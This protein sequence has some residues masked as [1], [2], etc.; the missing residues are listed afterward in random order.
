MRFQYGPSR[1]SYVNPSAHPGRG[2]SY[3]DPGLERNRRCNGCGKFADAD[4][5]GNS[6]RY[7][8]PYGHSDSYGYATTDLHPVTHLYSAANR[9]TGH[10]DHRIRR[11][12]SRG[13]YTDTESGVGFLCGQ[14]I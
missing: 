11:V 6:D 10:S 12:D 1:R 4:Q 2:S 3:A 14:H 7:P 9:Y 5:Q 8:C 13:A